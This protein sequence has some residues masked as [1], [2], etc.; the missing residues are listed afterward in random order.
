[1][2]THHS[3]ITIINPP[4]PH[5]LRILL[6]NIRL[7]AP[8]LRLPHIMLLLRLPLRL[9]IARESRNRTTHRTGCTVRDAGAEIVQLAR[10]FLLLALGVLLLALALEVLFYVSCWSLWCGLGG[11]RGISTSLP[12]NPPT[13]SFALPTVWFQLPSLRFGSFFVTAPE[14]EAE[15]PAA[16]MPAWEASCSSSA[17]FC[18]ASP[19]FWGWVLVA[20]T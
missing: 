1:M 13:A 12:T 14:E 8:L 20:G 11:I 15:K 9:A 6:L 7:R 4:N 19:A 3:S 16:E 5:N 2:S 10:S 18:F 17:F